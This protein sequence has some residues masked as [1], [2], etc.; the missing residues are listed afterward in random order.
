M[1]RADRFAVKGAIDLLEEGVQLL[2]SAP[3]E[4][5][6]FYCIGSFPFVLAFLYFWADMSASPVA[7]SHVGSAALA[8]SVLYI[9]MKCWHSIFAS[10]IKA[11]LARQMAP[12]ITFR[13]FYRLFVSQT[14]FQASSLLMLPLSAIAVLPFAPLYAFYHNVS[15]I[16]DEERS[17]TKILITSWK[18]AT[19][20]PAQNSVLILILSLLALVIFLNIATAIL[21]IPELL[22]MLFGIETPFTLSAASLLNTTFLAVTGALTYLCL[23]PLSKAVY[24]LRCFY[25]KS[26][27]TGE[28][29][30]AELNSLTPLP[31]LQNF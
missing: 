25:G 4:L 22:R 11:M 28:D 18:L 1:R 10:G 29:L 14:I 13:R 15:L 12:P 5:L 16:S 20:W 30:K 31:Q 21:V 3:F 9:W 6:A 2:R 19:L 17:F 7:H 27:V 23:N 26:I 24:V 8:L